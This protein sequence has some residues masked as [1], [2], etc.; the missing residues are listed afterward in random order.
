MTS[1]FIRAHTLK[2]FFDVNAYLFEGSA[3][4]QYFVVF[5]LA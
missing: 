3:V 5:H 1:L 2:L 4:P